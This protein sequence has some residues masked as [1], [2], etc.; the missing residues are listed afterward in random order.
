MIPK[1]FTLFSIPMALSP[2]LSPSHVIYCKAVITLFIC[3]YSSFLSNSFLLHTSIPSHPILS[4]SFVPPFFFS[5]SSA[6]VS[7]LSRFYIS[8]ASGLCNTSV[9]LF[10]LS[11]K[12]SFFC[13]TFSFPSLIPTP[14]SLLSFSYVTSPPLYSVCF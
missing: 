8:F 6:F 2:H 10:L 14:F 7:S 4:I 5:Q 12:S 3:F 13:P 9:I 11:S 1:S